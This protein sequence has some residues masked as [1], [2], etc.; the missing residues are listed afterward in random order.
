LDFRAGKR[1]SAAVLRLNN[2]PLFVV[3]MR[4]TNTQGGWTAVVSP[5]LEA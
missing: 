2:L 3:Y 4:R 1:E 5:A